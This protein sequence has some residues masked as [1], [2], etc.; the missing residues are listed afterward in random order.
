MMGVVEV[1]IRG[2]VRGGLNNNACKR[3]LRTIMVVESKKA[4]SNN[5]EKVHVISFSN[6]DY[7][8]GFD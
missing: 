1:I 7:C 8:K 2:F 5:Q 3:H 4:K 6:E